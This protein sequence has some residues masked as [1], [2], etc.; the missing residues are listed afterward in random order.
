MTGRSEGDEWTVLLPGFLVTGVGVGLV[1]PVLANIALSTVPD[2]QSGVASGINDTFR[3]VGVATGVAALGVL[4][5][6]RATDYIESAA[7]LPHADARLLADGVSFGSLGSDVPAPLVAAARQGFLEGFND[8]LAVGAG[9]ALL[10]AVL[11][12]LLVRASDL[13][14]QE[15]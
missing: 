10:G 15:Q 7:Q 14:A 13:I 8:I 12:V 11:T 2:E 5:T 1:N 3:Q 9:L 6:A 4:L